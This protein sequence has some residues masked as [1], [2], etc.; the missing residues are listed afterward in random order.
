MARADRGKSKTD[1]I[2]QSIG[3]AGQRAS[4]VRARKVP[5]TDLREVLDWIV[6][7]MTP[8]ARS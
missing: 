2:P 6:S 7:V 5:H 1:L 4:Q 8:A 3:A